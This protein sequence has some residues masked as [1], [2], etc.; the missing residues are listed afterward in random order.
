MR[1]TLR[2]LTIIPLA[3]AAALL[4]APL[5]SADPSLPQCVNTE[6][7]NAEGGANT[8]CATP[9]N[10]QIDSSPGQFSGPWGDMWNEDGLFFP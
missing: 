6:G 5:A 2:T 1:L 7:S 4:A 3:A 10:V 9:G 8:E